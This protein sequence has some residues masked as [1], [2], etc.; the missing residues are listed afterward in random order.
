MAD[1]QDQDQVHISGAS[2]QSDVDKKLQ[3]ALGAMGG[4]AS[5]TAA[6]GAAAASDV[7]KKL[8]DALGAV[9][10]A[11]STTAAKGAAAASDV[12]KKLQDALGAV[13][14]AASTT[15]A[16]GAAA[17]SDVDKKLQDALGAMGGADSTTAAKSAAAA[18][19]APAQTPQV[20][21][22]IVQKGES[23]SLIAKRY[24]GDIHKWKQLYEANKA[25]IGNN[26]DLIQVGQELVIPD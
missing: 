13:G 17:A 18:S 21:K 16:K 8:Q 10:A 24:Y 5:T 26:P 3:D 7:D 15:A 9:G 6:K 14:A 2:S 25:V 20:K 11:A 12:D 22:H 4:A 19:A 23:L 1:P